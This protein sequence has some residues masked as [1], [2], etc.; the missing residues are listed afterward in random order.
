MSTKEKFYEYIRA[1]GYTSV[2]QLAIASGIDISNLHTNVVHKWGI[3]I[4]RAFALANT[5]K[6]PVEEILELFYGDEFEKNRKI[7]RN[8]ELPV[9]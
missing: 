2:R 9:E 1:H 8:R 4:K 5:M 7:V 6:V 3:S